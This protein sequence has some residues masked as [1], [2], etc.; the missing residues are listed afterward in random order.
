MRRARRRLDHDLA[1]A[2]RSVQ[3]R[4]AL[5]GNLDPSVLYAPPRR[6]AP[7]SEGASELRPRTGHVFNL[8]RHPPDVPP[9]ARARDGR[10]RARAEPAVPRLTRAR[11]AAPGEKHGHQQD[12][13]GEDAGAT[14]TC[15]SRSAGGVPV[16]YEL[17]KESGALRVDRFLNTAMFYPGNYGFIRTRCRRWRPGG[18]DRVVP[19]GR[20]RRDRARAPVARCS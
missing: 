13:I 18:R 14:S 16:K 17:D 11:R 8:A 7:R 9:G 19:A 4:V 3:D 1:D 2:R 5:Q 12:R 10:G 6:Y 20:G 15:S